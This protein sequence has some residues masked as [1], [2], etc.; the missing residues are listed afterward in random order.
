MWRRTWHH[1]PLLS[2]ILTDIIIVKLGTWFHLSCRCGS[3]KLHSMG[4]CHISSVNFPLTGVQ[5]GG[6]A[7][8]RPPPC[9]SSSPSPCYL[10][11][12]LQL[13]FN[14]YLSESKLQQKLQKLQQVE[15]LSQEQVSQRISHERVPFSHLHYLNIKHQQNCLCQES[16]IIN[17]TRIILC[18]EYI[19]VHL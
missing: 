12:R 11:C 3:L 9:H 2:C 7:A 5:N 4:L 14:K 18:S 17:L 8:H 13:Y 1:D 19:V 16:V 15:M 10:A 6:L